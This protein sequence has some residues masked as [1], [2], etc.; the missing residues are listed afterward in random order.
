[1]KQL[2]IF[3]TIRHKA[4]LVVGAGSIAARKIGLL[5][6][7][8]ADVSVV[9]SE[10]GS[11]VSELE[12]QGAIRCLLRNYEPTDLKG[13]KLVIAATNNA[14]LNADI[15]I[16]AQAENI[17][18][19][20]VDN[21]ELCSFLMPSIIDRNPIQI[22]IS[23]G[24]AS[25]VLA[26]LIRS[27]LEAS[28]PSAYG[29][30]AK[31][32]ENYRTKVKQAFA[33]VDLRRR[34]WE[35]VL[36]GPVSEFALSG[37]MNEA[38]TMLSE[39]IQSADPDPEY[40]GEVYLVGAGP[41]DPDLLTFKALRLMQKCDVV[42]YD[43]LVSEP[44]MALVRRDAEKIYAGKAS[45]NHS[46]SQENINQLLVRLAKQGKRVLRLKGGDPFVFGRGGEEIGELIEDN[47]KFQVVPGITA[48]SGCTTYA[49]IPL[50]HRDHSQACIFVTGHRKVDGDDLNWAML[51]HANQTVVFY[52]GLDN[53]QRICDA[54]KKHGRHENTPA[55][56]I[57]KGTTPDQRVLVGDL[58]TLPD[59]VKNN[60]VR[61]P[62]LIVVGEVVNL[63]SQLNWFKPS[64]K[65]Q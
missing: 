44:I 20:V 46:I 47:I 38:E 16:M 54:L 28:I 33:N 41:G 61:A 27:K 25:P 6:K 11:E 2:P 63:H 56:L 49:G 10:I 37:R 19:N 30:L 39:L 51:S 12:K 13:I 64:N 5:L 62:T 53:V 17:L 29:E 18:V 65:I 45:A 31:L 34:F 48:A 52:M 55:A 26:R 23:T 50:T 24:G 22:A 36:E 4:C 43:R 42:V 7:A 58:N 8:G 9:A 15:S 1:M 60:N 40:Q 57:E 21:P 3:L 32:V 35:S 59:L 14:Q